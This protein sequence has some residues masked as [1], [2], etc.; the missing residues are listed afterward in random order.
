MVSLIK[1]AVGIN[2]VDGCFVQDSGL[3][4]VQC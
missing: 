2:V 1:K 3:N 4:I